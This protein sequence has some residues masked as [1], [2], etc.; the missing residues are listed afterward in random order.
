[1]PAGGL[2]PEGVERSPSGSEPGIRFVVRPKCWPLAATRRDQSVVR[3]A[4]QRIFGPRNVPVTALKGYMGNIVSGCG[5]VELICSLIAVNRGRI[6]AILNCDQ[7]EPDLELDL[8]LKSP[9]PT[10]NPAFVNTNLTP[11]G[12]AAALVIRGCPAEPSGSAQL[13]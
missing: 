2:D 13:K 6:P 4:F 12:Q 7:P 9:R 11:N 8:V 3:A 5:A 1:M 10:R